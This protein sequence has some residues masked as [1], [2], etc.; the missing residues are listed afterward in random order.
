MRRLP[1]AAGLSRFFASYLDAVLLH[2]DRAA[3]RVYQIGHRHISDLLA[4]MLDPGEA[5]VTG[6]ADP[7]RIGSDENRGMPAVRSRPQGP[8][9]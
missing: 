5:A 9:S 6:L 8:T 1:G 7:V 3:P 4:M 2:A